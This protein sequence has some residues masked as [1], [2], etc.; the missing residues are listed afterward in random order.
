[1]RADTLEN[2]SG[3]PAILVSGD[4]IEIRLYDLEFDRGRTAVKDE[5]IHD[6]AKFS[7]FSQLG[8][9]ENFICL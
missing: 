6:Q 5:Y 9:P 1:M 3:Q 7:I 2:P 8:K 4:Q